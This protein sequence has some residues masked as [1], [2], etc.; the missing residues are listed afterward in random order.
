MVSHHGHRAIVIG[1]GIGGLTAAGALADYFE[2]VVV[3]ER[4]R[5]MAQPAS[6]SGTPQDRHPHGLLTGG[7]NAI[8][9][10]FPRFKRDLTDAGAVQVRLSSDTCHERPDVG[11]LPRRD[12]G[13]AVPCASR[14]LIE[15]TLRRQVEASANITLR[16]G[17]RVTAILSAHSGAR[18]VAFDGEKGAESLDADLVIDASGRGI[19]MLD[20]VNALNWPRPETSEVGVDIIYSTALLKLRPDQH[21]DWK[22]AVTLPKPPVLPLGATCL[23]LEDD[24]YMVTIADRGAR[25]RRG[26]WD[27][28]VDALRDLTSPTIYKAFHRLTPV[29]ELRHFGFPASVWRHYEMLPSLPRAALPMGDALCRFNPV[30][31][32]GMACAAQQAR[33]LGSALGRAGKDADPIASAQALFMAEV[34]AILQTPWNMSANADFAFPQTR[35]IKPAQFEDGRHF[36]AALFR[37]VVADPVVHRTLIEVAHLLKPSDALRTPEMM[38]RIEAAAAPAN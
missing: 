6:R 25:A 21:P 38:Q 22:I 3:L 11:Q 27:S 19:P 14:P 33:L 16:S 13:F 31:G 29:G 24:C 30:Y 37:A 36:E 5:L 23:P 9:D 34:G 8:H 15:H 4:D 26:T 32:Q 7:I 12:L 17:C 18:G 35:G 28:M 1:A 10:I 20:L 2:Q